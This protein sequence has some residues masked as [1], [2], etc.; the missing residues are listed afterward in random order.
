[1]VSEQSQE[2]DL[3]EI[4]VPGPSLPRVSITVTTVL[5]PEQVDAVHP[6]V[7]CVPISG[8]LGTTSLAV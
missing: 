6:A 3:I 2:A 5:H 7:G 8:H 1:M 4:L